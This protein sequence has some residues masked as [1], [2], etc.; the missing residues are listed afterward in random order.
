M[1]NTM[2]FMILGGALGIAFALALRR[3]FPQL[4]G[5]PRQVVAPPGPVNRQATRHQARRQ[6]KVEQAR[7]SRHRS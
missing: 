1:S 2:L 5:R 4:R 6:Q 7:K 3:F